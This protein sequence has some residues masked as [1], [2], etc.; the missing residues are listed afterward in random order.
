MSQRS[1]GAYPHEHRIGVSQN[2]L[3]QV[4]LIGLPFVSA[5]GQEDMRSGKRV[6]NFVRSFGS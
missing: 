4:H 6:R 1:V 5:V 2:Q 3:T